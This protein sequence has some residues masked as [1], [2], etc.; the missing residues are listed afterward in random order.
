MIDDN[1]G[2]F[3]TGTSWHNIVQVVAFTGAA[4]GHAMSGIGAT[5][6]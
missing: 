3:L 1:G 4:I 6:C 2:P 5:P